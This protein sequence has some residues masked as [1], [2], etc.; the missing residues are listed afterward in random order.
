M[1]DSPF[2]VAGADPIRPTAASVLLQSL[3][4][5]EP[6]ICGEEGL[7][8]YRN[9][10]VDLTPATQDLTFADAG[11]AD[12]ETYMN[13]FNLG[14]WT[15]AARLDGLA[16]ELCGEGEI[17]VRVVLIPDAEGCGIVHE[18]RCVLTAA[19]VRIDLDA[20]LGRDGAGILVPQEGLLA[21]RLVARGAARLTRGGWI[22]HTP[23]PQAVRLAISITTF[24][25][26]EAVA[27]TARRI[28][29]FLDARG[30][31]RAGGA[32]GD[33]PTDTR[34]TGADGLSDPGADPGATLGADVALFIV[35]NGGTAR[36]DDH[37][38]VMRVDNPN[39]GGAGGF[40]RGLTLAQDGGFTHCLFMDDDASFQTEALVRTVALLRLARSPR[41]AVAGAMISEARKWAMWENGSVF[42]GLCRPQFV[43]TDLRLPDEVT[44]MELA[45]ARPK[46][47][48]FYAG[49]WYFAFPVAAVEHFPFPFFV[50]GD[51][52][53][54]SLANRFDTVTLNGVV[55][56]QEDFSSK[57]S[58][59]TLYLDLRNH[60]H[61]HLV[62]PALDIGA[63]GTTKIALRFILRS[64]V[65]MHYGS[66]RAQL[67][68]WDDVMAGPGF[69]ADNVDMARRRPQIVALGR[70]E[71]WADT[72]P[73]TS[74]VA[75]PVQNGALRDQL[76][77]W[78]LNGH[79]LPFWRVFGRHVTAPSGYRGLIW[80]FWGA[81]AVR[82]Y[83]QSGTRGYE[84]VHSKRR[85]FAILGGMIARAWR[86][87]R[88]YGALRTAHR[89]G[90]A[91]MTTRSFWETSFRSGPPPGPPLSGLPPDPLLSGPALP[92]TAGRAAASGP[93][94]TVRT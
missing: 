35:D 4:L 44:E 14:T 24:R 91:K 28:G 82:F 80:P 90:Y 25:R 50:R 85:A 86:W 37:P 68:A 53:S 65:R 60:L 3:V 88:H 59:L 6:A 5:P 61:Q 27:S 18:A 2:P 74:D 84:V 71:A 78:T 23:D 58:A 77:K 64:I 79:L 87:R 41:A 8:L 19:G 36:I 93:P 47:Q 32:G 42:R 75:A 15:R 89:A 11:A 22:T 16:L 46:P 81:R 40:A 10:G 17:A 55:S 43:G 56:F 33:G 57:E 92:G 70:D 39:L 51:D 9:A 34:G 72:A 73:M 13:L 83:D 62:H 21:V 63:W 38:S 29:A 1:T 26:E 31:G 20:T 69:F 48:G 49:W 7:Y 30:A 54:F 67:A 66:A 52:I 45:A 76:M 12:F 94:D